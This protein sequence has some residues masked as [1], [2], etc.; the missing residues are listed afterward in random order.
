MPEAD[1]VDE[2][3]EADEADAVDE[4]D[5]VERSPVDRVIRDVLTVLRAIRSV[6][7]SWAGDP[8]LDR[9]EI[10]P[11]DEFVLAKVGGD[12]VVLNR[13]HPVA[14]A[15]LAAERTP[16]PCAHLMASAV[17]TAINTWSE[18]IV[19]ADEMLFLAAH[20]EVARRP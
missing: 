15:A 20:I 17:F 12:H 13:I 5:E 3:D 10:H 2:V 19:D 7:A 6:D 14:V 1:E 16:R 9:L 8:R 11:L 4:V 18:A